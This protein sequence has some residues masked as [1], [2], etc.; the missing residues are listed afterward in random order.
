MPGGRIAIE[1]ILSVPR[2]DGMRDAV[3]REM[4]RSRHQSLN[5]LIAIGGVEVICWK[6][7]LPFLR[8]WKQVVSPV[9][10]VRSGL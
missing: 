5:L 6:S 7:I 2:I 1:V 4:R 8:R 10:V 9:M 3:G